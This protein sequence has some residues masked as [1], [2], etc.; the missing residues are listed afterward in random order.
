MK[1]FLEPEL[2]NDS[3][4]VMA[5]S[6][7]DFS[8]SDSNLISSL[9][10]FVSTKGRKDKS[11]NLIIDL[12]CGPGNITELLSLRWPKS[13]VIGIDGSQ[14][15]IKTAL[16]RKRS[17]F[18]N[19]NTLNYYCFDIRD[20][21]KSSLFENN[22]VDLVVSNSFLHHLHDIYSFWNITKSLGSLDVMHFHRDLRRPKSQ[23][24]AREL[25]KLHLA[26]A[27]S[28][29]KR[30]Y[31]ASL[32]AAFTV[33]EVKSQLEQQCLFNLQVSEIDDRYLQVCG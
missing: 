3:L 10:E 16:E 8:L 14:Q 6:N 31:Y 13:T 32:L 5:Y 1:R 24:E 17:K 9:S 33:K 18:P 23:N 15:M 25:M 4:Q 21:I 26:D 28:I 11:I 12:G 22:L 29:L 19:V 27:P 20:I 2:M 7:A 30:D